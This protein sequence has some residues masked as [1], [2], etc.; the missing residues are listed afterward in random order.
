MA[1]LK[2]TGPYHRARSIVDAVNDIRILHPSLSKIYCSKRL[3]DNVTSQTS[4]L[5]FFITEEKRKNY[6]FKK[7]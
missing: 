2:R 4:Y 3:V 7:K 5:T 1:L 6:L